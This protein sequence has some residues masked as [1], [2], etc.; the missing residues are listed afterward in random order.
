VCTALVAVLPGGLTWLAVAPNPG[1][2]RTAAWLLPAYL[3]GVLCACTAPTPKVPPVTPA[4]GATSVG[5]FVPEARALFEGCMSVPESADSRTYLCGDVAVW[6]A[7]AKS[8]SLADVFTRTRK[9]IMGRYGADVVEV[10]GELPLAGSSWPSSRFAACSRADG[11]ADVEGDCRAGG[12]ATAVT[13]TGGR[14]RGLGCVAR[15]NARPLLARCL[16]LLEYVASHGNPEGDVLDPDA[17]VL[18]PRLPWRALAAPR[19]CQLTLS[20]TRAG[21]IRCGDA[22]FDWNVYRPARTNVTARWRGQGVAELA[23]ALPGA[24]PVEEVPCRLENQPTRC[25]RFTAP[26]EHGPLVVWAAAVEWED[27]ALFASCIFP[28]AEAPFPAVC[29]GAFSLP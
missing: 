12:Y 16:E 15:G 24:G 6:M 2:M 27:R 3:L 19:G 17:L 21:R 7:E 14:Q 22:S 28:A 29:N 10:K 9:R 13:A 1:V 8:G 18:P 20:T 5:P 23:E 25:A 26:T 11:G 4:E